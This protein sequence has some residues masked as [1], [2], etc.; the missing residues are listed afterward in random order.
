MSRRLHPTTAPN[1]ERT[2]PVRR[3]LGLAAAVAGG[4]L[5]TIAGTAVAEPVPASPGTY[6]TTNGSGVT[7]TA[8]DFITAVGADADAELV[9]YIAQQYNGQIAATSPRILSFDAVNPTTGSVE[10]NPIHVKPG[11]DL[12][13]PN[14][15]NAGLTAIAK[16]QVSQVATVNPNA[17]DG[18]SYCI[19]FARSSRSKKTDGTE[20]GLTFY[21]LTRDAV[22]WATIGGSYAPDAPLTT[23]QLRGIFECSITNWAQVGGQYGAVHV[24]V[25]PTSA[26][27]YTFFLQSIGSSLTNVTNGCG[28]TGTRPTQQNDGTKI[29]GDPQGI[30]PYA[31]TKWAAQLNGAPGIADLRGGAVL[32]R[33]PLSDSSSVAPV[34][35]YGSTP[36]YVL[37]PDFASGN[38]SGTSTQG[39]VLYNV[40]RNGSSLASLFGTSGFICANEDTLL[41]QFGAVPLGV[42]TTAT[43]YCGKPN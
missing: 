1:P 6:P 39:R 14:G 12:T 31:V 28:A 40:I 33:V 20:S 29:A 25:P 32:G 11:C 4:L 21:D 2:S 15:A 13:R 35:K 34:V 9:N 36:Y 27:T 5:V 22:T 8:S 17:G 10:A 16:N 18:S 41:P 26:A 7:P 43:E 42:D 23:V 19:D 3:S 37:N 30:A 38:V 24:Y